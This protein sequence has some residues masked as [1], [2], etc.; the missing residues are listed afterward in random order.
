MNLEESEEVSQ[1]VDDH[2]AQLDGHESCYTGEEL[3]HKLRGVSLVGWH[4]VLPA[5]LLID[6]Q[7]SAGRDPAGKAKTKT[8]L[9][10]KTGTQLYQIYT[11]VVSFKGTSGSGLPCPPRYTLESSR[12]C[13]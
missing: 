11:V 2:G 13:W 8:F 1:R 4:Q 3:L 12:W 6:E 10:L 9:R 5:F 7:L